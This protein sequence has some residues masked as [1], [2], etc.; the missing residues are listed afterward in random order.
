MRIGSV[1]T[2]GTAMTGIVIVT[3]IDVIVKC[4]TLKR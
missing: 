3:T 1:D 2:I 4:A